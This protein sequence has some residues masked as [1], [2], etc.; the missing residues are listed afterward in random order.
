MIDV[1]HNNFYREILQK[2]YEILKVLGR[3]AQRKTLLAYDIKIKKLVVVKLLTFSNDF[4]GEDLKLFESEAQILKVLEHPGIPDYLDYFECPYAGG[5]AFALVQSYIPGRSLAEY[6]QWKRR[7]TEKD[8]KKIAKSLLEILVY[9][10]KRLPSVIHR[11]IKPSNIIWA[12]RAYLIDFGCAQTLH[13]TNDNIIPIVG[14]CGYISPEQLNGAATTASDLYSLGATLITLST[15][16]QPTKLPRENMQIAFEHIVK[17]SS[18]F[19]RWLQWMTETNLKK[20]SP[21]AE[22]ALEALKTG[23]ITTKKL[24]NV[25]YN[26]P[27]NSLTSF[28]ERMWNNIFY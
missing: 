3:K 19:V 27:K 24:F 17:L 14:T 5:K 23:K 25:D 28:Y 8:I 9:L 12:D 7:F 16:I 1:Y 20:R 4:V 6:L 10:H 18:N 21:S 22:I 13:N 2:R 15:G 26:N 11:D